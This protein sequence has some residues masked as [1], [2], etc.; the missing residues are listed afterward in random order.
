MFNMHRLRKLLFKV[1]N[2][3]PDMPEYDRKGQRITP[4][5][6]EL[7]SPLGG[8]GALTIEK[9]ALS[10][11]LTASQIA[12]RLERRLDKIKPLLAAI[13]EAGLIVEDSG[14][15]RAPADLLERLE[16]ELERSGCNAAEIRDRRRYEKQREARKRFIRDRQ[17]QAQEPD[18]YIEDLEPLGEPLERVE[19]SE[20]TEDREKPPAGA[21][22]AVL[23]N[24][25]APD[26]FHAFASFMREA[27][28]HERTARGPLSATGQARRHL[29]RLKQERPEFYARHL[30]TPLK[31]SWELTG[32]GWTRTL[33][34][35]NTIRGALSELE[36]EHVAA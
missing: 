5:R 30:D 34:S 13:L 1:R 18:G 17:R 8:L 29:E 2:R 28:E 32:L 27:I 24:A 7:L 36:P 4:A 35:L 23:T 26:Q 25:N 12:E 11:G 16:L 20:A 10:P 22:D 6:S 33:Y 9:L 19:V 15:Y 21:P 31:L 14:A 3:A